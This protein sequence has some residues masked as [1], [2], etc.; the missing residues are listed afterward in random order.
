MRGSKK[1]R[2]QY[3]E[4]SCVRDLIK[5]RIGGGSGYGGAWAF[6]RRPWALGGCDGKPMDAGD[7]RKQCESVFIW[8]GD[9]IMRLSNVI[10]GL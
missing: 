9:H 7:H 2:F 5:R 1:G 4:L 3:K 6:E 10:G 8:V